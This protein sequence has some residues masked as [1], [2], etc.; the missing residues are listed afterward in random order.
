MI[1]KGFFSATRSLKEVTEV[2]KKHNNFLELLDLVHRHA[3]AVRQHQ[4][5][6]SKS[7]ADEEAP[8]LHSP[9][10]GENLQEMMPLQEALARLQAT[11]RQTDAVFLGNADASEDW[12]AA[13]LRTQSEWAEAQ[14]NAVRNT[15]AAL[16]ARME[17]DLLAAMDT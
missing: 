10:S 11:H 16:A 13:A 14:V 2:T 5:T 17:A 9:P 1:A 8:L 12:L 3:H 4:Q 7:A 15:D 6:P